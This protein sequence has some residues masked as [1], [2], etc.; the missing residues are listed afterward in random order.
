MINK[1][2][3][4]TLLQKEINLKRLQIQYLE[5]NITN[6]ILEINCLQQQ[7]Q[8]LEDMLDNVYKEFNLLKE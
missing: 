5:S 6:Q 4:F 7:L 3:Q 8:L 1:R 2:Q